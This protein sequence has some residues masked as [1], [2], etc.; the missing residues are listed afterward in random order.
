MN[1]SRFILTLSFI[2]V[3]AIISARDVHA[4][5][6][7]QS[8]RFSLPSAPGE[9]SS[10]TPTLGNDTSRSLSVMTKARLS[11][12]KCLPMEERCSP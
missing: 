8:G 4:E 5:A 6:L 10:F 7:R 11:R 3:L 1:L 2:A 9:L 12:S